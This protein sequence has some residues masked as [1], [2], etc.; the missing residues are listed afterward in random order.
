[1][2]ADTLLRGRFTL[3]QKAAGQVLQHLAAAGLSLGG[4]LEVEG[5]A[6]GEEM[7]VTVQLVLQPRGLRRTARLRRVVEAGTAEAPGPV[8]R[9]RLW[10]LKRSFRALRAEAGQTAWF[11]AQPGGVFSVSLSQPQPQPRKVGSEGQLHAA[12]AADGDADGDGPV[13]AGA[14]AAVTVMAAAPAL[15]KEISATEFKAKRINTGRAALL[16]GGVFAEAVPELCDWDEQPITFLTFIVATAAGERRFQV[17][18]ANAA[19]L[20]LQRL[21]VVGQWWLCVRVGPG[22]ACLHRCASSPS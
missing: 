22:M 3:A 8:I 2:S 18:G 20:L 10:A 7:D 12:A 6:G 9:Y 14:A 5:E 19:P 13:A 1:M 16:A 17:G 11:T 15:V 4:A 21:G